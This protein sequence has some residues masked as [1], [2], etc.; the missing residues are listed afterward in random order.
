[1]YFFKAKFQSSQ[2]QSVFERDML[3]KYIFFSN[4]TNNR[5]NNRDFHIDQN[6]RDYDFLHNRAALLCVNLLYRVLMCSLQE[7]AAVDGLYRIRVPRV[8]LQT[9]RMSERP[10]EGHLSAFVRAVRSSLC[11]NHNTNNILRQ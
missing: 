11:R 5:L 4:S 9:D 3:N 8:S 7:V 10:M 6:N 1:M 2:L